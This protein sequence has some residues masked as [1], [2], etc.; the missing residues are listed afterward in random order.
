[1]V[2]LST[3]NALLQY[4]KKSNTIDNQGQHESIDNHR[5]YE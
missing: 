5:H 3:E 4:N 1:M 2:Q